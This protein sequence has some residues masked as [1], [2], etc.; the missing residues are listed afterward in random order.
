MSSLIIDEAI[1]IGKWIVIFGLL[2]YIATR[3]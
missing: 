2:L 1:Y 3:V